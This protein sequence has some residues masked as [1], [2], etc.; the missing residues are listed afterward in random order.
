MVLLLEPLINFFTDDPD[1]KKA[2]LDYGY[3]RTFFLPIMFSSYTVNTAMRC[4]GD[5]RNPLKIMVIT[6]G[7][8]II[9]DPIFMFDSIN[10]G[11]IRIPGLGLG[12]FGAALA[13]VISSTFAFLMAFWIILSGRTYIKINPRGLLKLDKEIDKKLI[14]IGLPNGL[15]GLNRNIA[16]FILFKMIAFYGV[17]AVAAY[18]I[19][20]R[21]MELGFM[22]L[23]GLNMGG[24]SIVGQNLGA[25]NMSRVLSTIHATVVLGVSIMLVINVV[26]FIG[27]D[28]LMSAFTRDQ[29]VIATGSLILRFVIPAMLLIAAM[30]GFGTS[31]SGSGYN[32]PFLISSVLSRWTVL[33]PLAITATYFLEIGFVGLLTAF[34]LSE[35]TSLVIIYSYYRK[36]KWKEQRV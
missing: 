7:M 18:G 13:T 19:V 10:L 25:K 29:E 21:I 27:G 33:I 9:L 17:E 22:P 6:A 14:T 32:K 4:I 5:S 24:S 34:I 11:F 28:L 12:V 36:G 15:E 3:I 20:L 2:A 31:F 35:L 1:T 30:F 16:N 23:F 26:A 8:N